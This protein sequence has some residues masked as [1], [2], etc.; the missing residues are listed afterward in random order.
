MSLGET[1]GP[2]LLALPRKLSLTVAEEVSVVE[3]GSTGEADTR[4]IGMSP[5]PEAVLV[6][7]IGTRKCATTGIM[8]GTLM[9]GGMRN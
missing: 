6:I 5:G 7:E 1:S 4:R 2:A 9:L 3:A 8:I